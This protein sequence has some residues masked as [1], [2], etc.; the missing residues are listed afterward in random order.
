MDS[1]I[2]MLGTGVLVSPH[3][4]PERFRAPMSPE[5]R[6]E[7]AHARAGDIVYVQL[8][9]FAEFDAGDGP[10]RWDSTPQG[11]YP[12]PTTASA[13]TALL[14]LVDDYER[15]QLGN[16]LGDFGIA[17]VKVSR[18]AFEAS[19]RRIDVDDDLA[20]RLTLD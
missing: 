12:L 3:P 16:L 19:P 20:A 14:D 4:D 10:T 11:P 17:G 7:L 6:G 9:F 15:D 1:A 5:E 8:T 13:T 18:F 2:H